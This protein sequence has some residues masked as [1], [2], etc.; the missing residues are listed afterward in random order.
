MGKMVHKSVNRRLFQTGTI[1]EKANLLKAREIFK[2]P[3]SYIRMFTQ[4]SN[5]PQRLLP[6][7]D[8]SSSPSSRLF[9]TNKQ[10]FFLESFAQKMQQWSEQFVM[11]VKLE[12]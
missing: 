10:I 4:H 8:V 3:N 12:C 9:Q 2:V 6:T 7:K 1:I 5:I 11:Q